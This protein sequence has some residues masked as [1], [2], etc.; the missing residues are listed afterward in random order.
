MKYLLATAAGLAVAGPACAQ[1]VA[2][3]PLID[4]RLRWEHAEQDGLPL[5][6]EAVTV[7][8]RGGASFAVERWT[9]LVEGQANVPLVDDYYDGLRG[10]PV[11][12]LVSD[13][14]NVALYR[15]Q[16]QYKGKD[17]VVTVGRQ[18]IQLDDERFVGGSV[19][20]QNGQTFDAARVE[21]TPAKGLKADLTYAWGVRTVWGI[22]GTGARPQAI[23]GDNVFANLSYASP[24]GTVTAFAYLV[25]QDDARVQGFRLSS[26]S[27]G[28][29]LV[30]SRALSAKAKLN[31]AASFA[32]QSDYRRNPNDYTARY[33]LL[34]GSIEA[35]GFRAGATYEVLGA[36]N[37]AA[38]TSF[39]APVG[40]AFRFH[41]WA[42]KFSPNPPDGVRDLFGTLAYTLPKAGKFSAITL[43]AQYHR[44]ESDRLVRHY[45]N[46]LDMMASA[47]LG[48]YTFSVRYADYKADRFAT[49]TRKFW[50]QLDWVL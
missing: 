27:Y 15:A 14:E 33:Y 49:D 19:F 34:D 37:G 7:R 25:D 1:D 41:G 12:P 39:Q 4:A 32:E 21:W 18:R 36:S 46:E 10:T 2:V 13:P 31:Y 16:L 5:D 40:T 30:G 28:M 17:A 9:A 50:L 22:E 26:Q 44:F 42:G 29:R 6:A 24:V 35:S 38:L 45:G 43:Q 23:G 11:R 3:K 20:R 48:K 8:V 47:K